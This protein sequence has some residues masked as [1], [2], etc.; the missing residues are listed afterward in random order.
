V[1]CYSG[2]VIFHI[3][4]TSSTNTSKAII[5]RLDAEVKPQADRIMHALLR[6]L[7]SLS[8]RS[9]VADS[10]FA[11]VGALANAL[12]EDFQKYMDP[13]SEYLF[14]ALAN[15]EEP[16]LCAMAIGLVSDITRALQ[17]HA[18]P[19]CDNFMNHLL[20]NLK[21]F[22]SAELVNTN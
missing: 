14:R 20:E 1:L 22:S 2:K 3:G 15:K 8:D 9:S 16:G 4:V 6:L 17:G 10:D 21:V 13:F 5:Q 18:Q 12:E 7:Q 19:Y 11:A